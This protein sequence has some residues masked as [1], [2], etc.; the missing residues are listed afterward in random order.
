MRSARVLISRGAES[1][2]TCHDFE[3]LQCIVGRASTGSVLAGGEAVTHGDGLGRQLHQTLAQATQTALLQVEVA[4]VEALLLRQVVQQGAEVGG[5]AG[6]G[7]RVAAQLQD[8]LA[9]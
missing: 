5:G 6:G 4:D 1:F 8:L 9:R 7:Q 2:P 3:V